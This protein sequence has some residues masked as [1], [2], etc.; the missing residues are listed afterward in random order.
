MSSRLYRSVGSI[1]VVALAMMSLWCPLGATAYTDAPG[2]AEEVL[3]SQD[4]G[5]CSSVQQLLDTELVNM[6]GKGAEFTVLAI[7]QYNQGYNFDAYLAALDQYLTGASNLP[8][9]TMQKIVLVQLACGG[10]TETEALKLARETEGRQGIMSIVF[11]LH[12]YSN[13]GMQE[14]AER[15]IGNILGQQST[16]GGWGLSPETP[17]V[18]ITAM[19]LQAMAPYS[20]DSDVK[21]AMDKTLDY[22]RSAQQPSGGFLSYGV[23]NCESVAQ[24][25]I[26]L[27]SLG[28][29]YKAEMSGE[30]GSLVDVMLS[31][32]LETGSFAHVQGG[33]FNM[34]ATAQAVLALVSMDM[35][36]RGAGSVFI[37]GEYNFGDSAGGVTEGHRTELNLK[38]VQRIIAVV[39]LVVALVYVLVGCIRRKF[40][41]MDIITASV[42]GLAISGFIFFS[43]IE[44][45]EQY[46]SYNLPEITEDSVTV[47]LSIVGGEEVMV[48]P[49]DFVL[50]EGD[51]VF[52]LV[53]RVTRAYRIPLG[54][55]SGWDTYVSS[56]GDLGEG[57]MGSTSGWV[58]FVNGEQPQISVDRCLLNPGDVVEFQYVESYG[59]QGNE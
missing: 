40:S 19:V 18:D 38:A 15:C 33:Q 7:R 52:D 48:S 9:T 30:F 46:Y 37:L 50:L 49:E 11:A 14:D 17:T 12:L 16:S 44:T 43:N 57:D 3:L 6:A 59:G 32:R 8:V 47:S 41:A 45:P 24:V 36:D 20:Q 54:Y 58:Y 23:E 51:T 28:M 27:A 31:Y 10:I 4:F 22:L 55:V 21:E 42:A 2:Q 39:V 29:D 53:Y 13:L 5:S 25:I 26:A 1:L 34:T 35:A 56:I